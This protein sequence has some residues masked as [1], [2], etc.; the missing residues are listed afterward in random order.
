MKAERGEE[1]VEEK[2]ETSRGWFMRFKERSSVHDIKMQGEVA[3]AGIEAMQVIQ[4]IL[5]RELTKVALNNR[6]SK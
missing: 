5:L 1:A 2:F 4:E 6:Y 3:N